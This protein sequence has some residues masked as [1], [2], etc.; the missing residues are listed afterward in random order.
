[1]ANVVDNLGYVD[2]YQWEVTDKV[3]GGA[4]GTAVTPI[5][6]LAS[7]DKFILDKLNAA[8][9]NGTGFSD[10]SIPT[11]KQA[12]GTRT[13]VF[14]NTMLIGPYDNTTGLP[15]LMSSSSSSV[16]F[17][18]AGDEVL[19]SFSNGIDSHGHQLEIPAYAASGLTLSKDLAGKASATYYAYVNLSGTTVTLDVSAYEPIYDYIAPATPSTDQ[20]WFDINRF[21]MFRW[22]GSAWVAVK[23]VFVGNVYFSGTTAGTPNTYPYRADYTAGMSIPAGVVNAF[24]GAFVKVPRGWL[25]CDGSA[26]SRKTYSRLFEIIGTAFGAGNGSTTFNIPDLRGR[27]IIGVDGTYLLAATQTTQT[28]QS[29]VGSEGFPANIAMNYI[30][31]Y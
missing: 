4:S 17:N 29:G 28:V 24:V 1:M 19:I 7:R 14:R 9:A 22:S 11:I 13:T 5:K 18:L 20:H 15:S 6:Q 12:D 25:Y 2:V 23:R 10:Y 31:K 21:Q 30:I 16:I 3:L 26:V 27:V 8:L